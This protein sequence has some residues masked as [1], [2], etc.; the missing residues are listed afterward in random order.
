MSV[1]PTLSRLLDAWTVEP[2]LLG[3]LCLAA[4]LYGLG[5][6]R[7]RS[8]WPLLRV[9]SFIGGLFA[10]ALAL[11]SGIDS[12]ADVSLSAHVLQ[13]LLL[14]LIAPTLLLWGAP[15]RLAL[16][17]CP[18]A[19]RQALGRLLHARL[20]HLISRPA[21]GLALFVVVVLG[22]QLTGV[23]E[24]AL[25]DRML[26]DGEHF[27]YLVA[28]TLLLAPLLAADPIPRPP[29]AIARFAWLMGAMLTMS[30]P[31]S[32]LLFDAHIL[33]PSYSITGSALHISALAD[34]RLAGVLMLVGG[35]IAMG[36]LAIAIAMQA[37]VAEERRQQRRDAAAEPAHEVAGDLA[38]D[39]TGVLARGEVGGL[40]GT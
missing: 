4:A 8:R 10:I 7:S 40:A 17:A 28:G 6:V 35:G 1:P 30:I 23:Y 3:A 26:H 18:P 9:V 27:A 32:V 20:V 15:L 31:A 16:S 38:G 5:V 19:G 29:G 13:H 36:A 33:Y 25:R 22:T 12:Y 11:L 2:P 24:E 37:M 34:Q 39:A 14:I 21:F